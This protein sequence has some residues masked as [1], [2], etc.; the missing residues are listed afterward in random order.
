MRKLAQSPRDARLLLKP[1]EAQLRRQSNSRI[2]RPTPHP[3]AGSMGQTVGLCRMCRF[4]RISSLCAH[5]RVVDPTV[6]HKRHRGEVGPRCIFSRRSAHC[7]L[8]LICGGV[9]FR[10]SSNNSLGTLP[11]MSRNLLCYL[12]IECAMLPNLCKI[13]AMDV[14]TPSSAYRSQS[15]DNSPIVA[16]RQTV[17]AAVMKSSAGLCVSLR[18]MNSSY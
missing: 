2:R 14:A 12:R 16:R 6:R 1:Q 7:D 3:R 9:C 4:E 11:V 17:R 8:S 13:R 15:R 18:G 5:A 10:Q